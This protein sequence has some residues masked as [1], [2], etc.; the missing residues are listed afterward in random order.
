MFKNR[1]WSIHRHH[2]FSHRKSGDSTVST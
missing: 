1:P 2:M